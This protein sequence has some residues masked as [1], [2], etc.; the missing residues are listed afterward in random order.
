M[1][2]MLFELALVNAVFELVV[3]LKGLGEPL[4]SKLDGSRPLPKPG[5]TM[6]NDSPP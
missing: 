4:P 2:L 5:M 1:E 6:R 3:R